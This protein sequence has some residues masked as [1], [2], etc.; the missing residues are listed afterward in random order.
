M[1]LTVTSGPDAVDLTTLNAVKGHL[2]E[3]SP[4]NVLL[5]DLI[6]R[7]SAAIHR[8]LTDS[9]DGLA[10][11]TYEETIAGRGDPFLTVSRTPVTDVASAALDGATL[12]DVEIED[13]EAGILYRELGFRSTEGVYTRLTHSRLPDEAH[14]KITVTYTAGYV[15]PGDPDPTLPADLEQAAIE[16][17]SAW[18]QARQRDPALVSKKVG[19]VTKTYAEGGA[20]GRRGGLPANALALLA[21]YRRVA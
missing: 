5:Q 7:A 16:A 13:A 9:V 21:P 11:Q 8:L 17:V 14:P 1:A 3:S 6:A 2:D 20:S 10:E 18:Y 4:D 12:S 15:M 19:D